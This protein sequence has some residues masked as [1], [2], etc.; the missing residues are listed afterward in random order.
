[1]NPLS[2]T[3]DSQGAPVVSTDGDLPEVYPAGAAWMILGGG[4]GIY[5]PEYGGAFGMVN[6]DA[7]TGLR[8][9]ATVMTASAED[10]EQ[11]VADWGVQA[12]LFTAEGQPLGPIAVSLLNAKAWAL[13]MPVLAAGPKRVVIVMVT[14][15]KPGVATTLRTPGLILVAAA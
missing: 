12:A 7:A 14:A 5:Q 11:V 1:M 3:Y 9:G 6:G 4:G 8:W 2:L 13:Q 10:Q 15:R